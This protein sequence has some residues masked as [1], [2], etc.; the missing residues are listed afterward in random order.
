MRGFTRNKGHR[1][2]GHPTTKLV[3]A[4]RAGIVSECATSGEG[5]VPRDIKTQKARRGEGEVKN[6]IEIVNAENKN[7]QR[8][9]F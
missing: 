9:N 7:I 1:H 8:L 2:K 3:G 5:A 4:Q 6:P